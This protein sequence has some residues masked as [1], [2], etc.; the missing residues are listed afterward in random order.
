MN[1]NFQQ[2]LEKVLKHEGGF[3]NHPADPGG[4]TNKGITLATYRRYI[5]KNG[6]VDD[7]KTLT[8]EQAGKVYKAQYWDKVRGD[9]LPSGLDYAVF[10]FAVNSGPA[11]AAKE[12][13]KA[14]GVT[15]DGIIGPITLEAARAANTKFLIDRL[16]DNRLAFLKRL[17][18]WPTFGKGWDRRVAEVRATSKLMV[19]APRAVPTP[20]PRPEVPANN[21]LLRSIMTIL[22][23]IFGGKK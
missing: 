2:A 5:K 8:I 9:D 16:C 18:T 23:L 20:Q 4:A 13:Q 12:L 10:D 1:K 15:Q 14:L 7:L 11:K 6:T 3:V 22:K 17:K 21:S 19:E